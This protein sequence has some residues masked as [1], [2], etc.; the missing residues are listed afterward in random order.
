MSQ[1]EQTEQQ[2]LTRQPVTDWTVMVY[3]AGDNNL[4]ADCIWAL[5]EMKK[6]SGVKGLNIIA[7][8]DP[9]DGRAKTRRYKI[10]TAK[11]TEE[12]AQDVQSYEDKSERPLDSFVS[13]FATYDPKTDE[14][15]FLNNESPNAFE[16]AQKRHDKR[17]ALRKEISEPLE[18]PHSDLASDTAASLNDTNTASPITLY[19][20]LSWGIHYFPARHYV[21]V[22]SA[23]SGGIEPSYL[24]KDESSGAYM[25]FRDLKRV[26]EQLKTDLTDRNSVEA[27]SSKTIDI[28]GFDSCLMS[29]A[30][31]CYELHGHVEIV[32]GSETYTP[33]SGWPYLEIL[34]RLKGVASGP[35][36]A[37]EA[38]VTG[39]TAVEGVTAEELAKH[40]VKTYADFYR[41]YAEAG[42][43]VALSAMRVEKMYELIRK[44][45]TLTK[46]MIDELRQEHPELRGAEKLPSHPF[47]DALIL[48]HWEA[49]SYNG[50]WYVDLVDFCECL[51]NRTSNGDVSLACEEVVKFVD[52]E[53]VIQSAF[54]GP[55]YQFSRGV[56]VYFP[57]STVAPYLFQFKFAELSGWAEFLAYYT[58]LTRRKPTAPVGISDP[59]KRAA[60]E[61][62]IRE[63]EKDG[64]NFLNYAGQIEFNKMGSDK[65]AFVRMGSD[66]MGSDKMGSDKMGS[67]KSGNPIHSMRN[68]PLVWIDADAGEKAVGQSAGK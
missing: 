3:M 62:A 61:K 51:K 4:S 34:Q 50:E 45:K 59:G 23:H 10:I 30:E 39:K 49:Q 54:T 7:Q 66:K 41:D 20:F 44:V 5:T 56:S 64:A 14:I 15:L 63:A 8:F 67:D 40:T 28:L 38:T 35:S 21:I 57:W 52:E 43:S 6:L 42:V 12:R 46:A 53:L 16:L 22:L 48:A 19:N 55:D 37:S 9:S 11:E 2:I 60:I 25:S 47:T 1:S 68:P 32:I 36:G 58:N 17:L 26:F 24:M 29:M 65:M 33:S 31:I 13:G 18:T 27:G